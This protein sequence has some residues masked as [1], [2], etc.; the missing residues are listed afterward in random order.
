[1]H[2][3]AHPPPRKTCNRRRRRHG[4][5]AEPHRAGEMGTQHDL[6]QWAAYDRGRDTIS[7]RVREAD[8]SQGLAERQLGHALELLRR[9]QPLAD[10]HAVTEEAA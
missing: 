2:P 3:N 4:A 9:A 8:P 7:F 6:E 1:M 5:S 10:G